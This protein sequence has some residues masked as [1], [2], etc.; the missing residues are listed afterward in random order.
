MP[1]VGAVVAIVLLLAPILGVAWWLSRPT[2]GVETGVSLAELDVVCLGRV[3]G[4]KPVANLEPLLPGRVMELYVTEGQVV[5]AGDK[6]L[7]LDDSS[8]KLKEDEA[9]EAVAG[10]DVEVKLAQQEQKLYPRRKM[11]QEAA[12]TTASERAE[13][14]RGLYLERKAAKTF[15]TVTAAELISA[16]TETKQLEHLVQIEKAKL[17]E[18]VQSDPGLRVRATETK[19][20]MAEISLEQA[21]K[22]V[23]DC[24]LTA[25]AD[26]VILRVQTSVGES[27]TPGNPSPAIVF[28]PHGPLVVRAELEQEYLGRV[29][30]GMKAV[31]CDDVQP[32]SPVWNGTVERL[33]NWIARKRSLIMDPGE[34]NDVRTVEC[35]VTLTGKTDGL[36]VGQRMRVRIGKSAE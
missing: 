34:V 1:R 36:L 12:V 33:G 30:P 5:K 22:A 17:E 35:V 25:P 7:K 13:A 14:S 9:R 2:R 20:T 26:G 27:V 21:K 3:D 19:K 31:I 4:L 11:I 23:R 24:L 6:L 16:E 28:R 15:G 10:A 29:K 18:L 32:D 8:L